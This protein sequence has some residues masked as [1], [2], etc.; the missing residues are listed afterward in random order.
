MPSGEGGK[1]L[2]KTYE[3]DFGPWTS[4]SLAINTGDYANTLSFQSILDCDFHK[5]RNSRR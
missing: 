3:D 5:E 4:I 2:H 1:T